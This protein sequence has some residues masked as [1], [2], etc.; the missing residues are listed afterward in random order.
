M[1]SLGSSGMF[2]F[3]GETLV[4]YPNPVEIE[5]DRDLMEKIPLI[6][7]NS[8]GSSSSLRSRSLSSEDGGSIAEQS[9]VRARSPA[10]LSSSQLRGRNSDV[11]QNTADKKKL[12]CC[13]RV[14]A[15]FQNCFNGSSVAYEPAMGVSVFT[16]GGRTFV[17]GVEISS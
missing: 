10:K 1:N 15:F 3:E 4:L 11:D 12:S 13:E 7:K 5:L 17:N 16:I 9:G 2:R 14:T 6:R 8:A